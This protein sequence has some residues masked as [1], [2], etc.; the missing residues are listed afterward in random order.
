MLYRSYNSIVITHSMV[1]LQVT[2]PNPLAINNWSWFDIATEQC[3]DSNHQIHQDIYFE[4]E[5]G[6]VT[7]TE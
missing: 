7:I 1:T 2:D 4:E 6:I 5:V 3:I